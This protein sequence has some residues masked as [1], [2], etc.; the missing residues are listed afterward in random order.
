LTGN[1][2]MGWLICME[3]HAHTRA[4]AQQKKKGYM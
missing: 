2:V 3:A 4:R 1:F